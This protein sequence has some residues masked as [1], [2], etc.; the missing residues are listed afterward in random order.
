LR[1]TAHFPD[2]CELVGEDGFP[3][4]AGSDV[5]FWL[6]PF[7]TLLLEIGSQAAGPLPHRNWTTSEAAQYGAP[8]SLNRCQPQPWMQVEFADAARFER[9]GMHL[10]KQCFTSRLPALA[11]GRH[12]LAITV[13][14]KQGEDD[15]RYSPVVTE[16]VQI[17]GRVGGR[18]IQMIPVPDARRYGNTQHAGC[19]W[20]LNKIPLASR[21]SEELLEFAMYAYLPD[22][23]KA[24]PEA[25]I[26]K[27]WWQESSRPEADGFYGD[28]PS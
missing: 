8:L 13:K 23:V 27:Q 12:V 5:E 21:H 24:I 17:R 14:L 6:R 20:V 10:L 16:I 3:F 7:E 1:V 11:Q 4:R 22:K 28:A 18:D 25:W 9:A 26:V 19:S 15:Y 2:R